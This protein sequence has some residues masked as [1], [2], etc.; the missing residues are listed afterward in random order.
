MSLDSQFITL[1][2][3]QLTRSFDPV[4]LDQFG[5]LTSTTMPV[6]DSALIEVESNDDGLNRAAESQ[7]FP[8]EGKG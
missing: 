1:N 8:V 5:L 7:Q 3:A 4:L 6:E 2:L